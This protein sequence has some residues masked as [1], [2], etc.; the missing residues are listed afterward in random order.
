MKSEIFMSFK[1]IQ[2]NSQKKRENFEK[3]EKIVLALTKR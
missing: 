3:L 2:Y 1:E